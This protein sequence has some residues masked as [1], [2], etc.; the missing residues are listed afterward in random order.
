MIKNIMIVGCRHCRIKNNKTEFCFGKGLQRLFAADIAH[1]V[2]AD[3]TVDDADVGA[4]FAEFLG[5]AKADA[6][7]T[8]ADLE[9][10][11]KLSATSMRT[12]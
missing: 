9:E 7:G 8:C 12:S 1:I 11:T 2:V 3:R 6:V 10:L 5:R 4:A